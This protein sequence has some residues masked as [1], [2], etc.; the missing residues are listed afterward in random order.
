MGERSTRAHT[1]A[2]TQIAMAERGGNVKIHEK[3]FF[4]R[5]PSAVRSRAPVFLL[6]YA[7]R[8]N[9]VSPT[10]RSNING[11]RDLG[12][13]IRKVGV[14][15]ATT[16]SP[17]YFLRS[18]CGGKASGNIISRDRP[19]RR[20]DK[21]DDESATFSCRRQWFTFARHSPS[22]SLSL[23]LSRRPFT[24]DYRRRQPPVQTPVLIRCRDVLRVRRGFAREAGFDRRASVRNFRG[25]VG[26]E[27]GSLGRRQRSAM[28]V[29]GNATLRLCW[30]RRESIFIPSP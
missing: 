12:A 15:A 30:L 22:L 27:R 26:V 9:D 14:A 6:R 1:H 29:T 25:G 23:S 28:V 8:R 24:G 4:S 20:D 3:K 21:S 10:G 13:G 5:E 7:P 18:R 19:R 11:C 2:D 16:S 17:A